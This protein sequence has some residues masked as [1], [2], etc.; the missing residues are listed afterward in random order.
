MP[1]GEPNVDDDGYTSAKQV[2]IEG[3]EVFNT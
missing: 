2:R 3:N 1:A